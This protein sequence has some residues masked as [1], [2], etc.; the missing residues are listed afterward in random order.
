MLKKMKK[1]FVEKK[2]EVLDE[3][4]SVVGAKT[5]SAV[6][7]LWEQG[8]PFPFL[9]VFRRRGGRSGSKRGLRTEPEY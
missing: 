3:R 6:A 7:S 4:K 5:P 1:N 9:F 8:L 2:S